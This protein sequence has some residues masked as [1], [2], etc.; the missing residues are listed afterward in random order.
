M[1]DRARTVAR[2]LKV[3]TLAESLGGVESLVNH[4]VTMTHAAVPREQRESFGLTE[5]LLRLSVG[6]EDLADLQGD[7]E[8]GLGT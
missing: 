4:P 1:G 8:Q 2:A 6:I 5:G 3:F 7:L